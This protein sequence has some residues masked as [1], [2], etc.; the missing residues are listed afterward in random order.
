MVKACALL[1]EEN[2]S[3]VLVAKPGRKRLCEKWS[4]NDRPI[5]DLSIQSSKIASC[6]HAGIILSLFDP[7]NGDN[8]FLW[9]VR[10]F[11]ND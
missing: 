11:S 3:R 8:M 9:N 2:I 10:W 5:V 1:Q 6:F 7:E 4:V